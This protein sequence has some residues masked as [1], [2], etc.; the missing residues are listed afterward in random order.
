MSKRPG[1]P[2]PAQSAKRT[3]HDARQQ[4]L[5]RLMDNGG[6]VD[7]EAGV[8]KKPKQERFPSPPKLVRSNAFIDLTQPGDTQQDPIEFT[9]SSDGEGDEGD[10]GD[11]S[12]EEESHE[13]QMSTQEPPPP[14]P[15]SD[16]DSE[17]DD[18]ELS[19]I[20]DDASGEPDQNPHAKDVNKSTRGVN[21]CF[22]CNNYSAEAYKLFTSYNEQL[23]GIS[24]MIIAKEVGKSGTP[25]L[26]AC[27]N[28]KTQKSM[29]QVI[30]LFPGCHISRVYSTLYQA[31]Q[32][33]TKDDKSPFVYGT[34][35][36]APKDR[37]TKHNQSKGGE[38]TKAKWEKVWSDA[39]K[40][41]LES[42]PPDIRV[43]NYRTIKQISSDYR[44]KADD[45]P[46]V[47]G[48]WYWGPA[49]TGKTTKAR[50]E[51]P[52]C[53]IKS[54]NKW[55]DGYQNEDV[56]VL[57]DLDPDSAKF[58]AGFLKDWGDRYAFNCCVKGATMTIRPKKFIVTSQ[59]SPQQL[60]SDVPTFQAINR[61]YKVEEF[62]EVLAPGLQAAEQF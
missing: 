6:G 8:S 57:D 11:D 14:P 60:F 2:T 23:V 38:A 17:E 46:A 27:V 28:F 59:Y 22:T 55:W 56:V 18:P 16:E 3:R 61:R 26:Q 39:Q 21:W 41:D 10:E 33:C 37:S 13:S 49:G 7:D 51:N 45:L 34:P 4:F 47:C 29:N 52:G 31:W 20:A 5:E 42:I 35:P 50:S 15:P 43:N 40:G 1:T 24:R 32:Y 53:Y 44:K 58:L 36:V 25:H 9:D 48:V 54:R 19:E 62:T 12:D 30:K